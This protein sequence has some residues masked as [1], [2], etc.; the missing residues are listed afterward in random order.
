LKAYYKALEEEE[1]QEEQK[2]SGDDV[3]TFMTEEEVLNSV[4]LLRIDRLYS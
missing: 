2:A 3:Q 1:R 4:E